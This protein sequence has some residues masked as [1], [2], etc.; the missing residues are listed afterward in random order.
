M[1]DSE[2]KNRNKSRAPGTSWSH[3]VK[4]SCLVQTR[5]SKL[6]VRSNGECP[7]TLVSVSI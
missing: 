3:G 2:A 5:L 4:S 7:V 1:N 6:Q